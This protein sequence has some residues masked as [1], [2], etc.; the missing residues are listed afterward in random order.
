VTGTLGLFS[1]VDLFQLVAAASRT[2]R[3]GVQ[4]PLGPA[5]VYFDRGRV[6]H[7]EF[8]ALEGVEAAYALFGDERGTFEF[9]SGLPA[10]RRTVEQSTQSLVLE[11]LRRLDEER[12]D[13]A[14]AVP[15]LDRGAVPYAPDDAPTGIRLGNDERRVVS[16]IDGQMTVGRLATYLA[17]P[18]DDVQRIV[19]RLMHVGLLALRAKRPRTAQLVVRLADHRRVRG[20]VGVDEGILSNWA[21]VV[22]RPIELVAVR[23]ADG[24][25]FA[26]P[27]VGITGGGPYLHVARDTLLRL[28]LRADDTVLVKPHFP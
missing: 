18:V 27:V 3:L 11:A 25:A 19:A 17:L 5:R 22:E 21:T 20:G 9:V 6:V 8:G 26:V 7:V 14:P 10:P 13:D 16:A 4:H 1:L 23:R 2:G 15:G 28:D 12:R 24:N